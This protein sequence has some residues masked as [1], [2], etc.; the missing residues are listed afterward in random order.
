MVGG[1]HLV[2]TFSHLPGPEILHI[3]INMA[4]LGITSLNF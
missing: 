4:I 2:L 1:D 3:D